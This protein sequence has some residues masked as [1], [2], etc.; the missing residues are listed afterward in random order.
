MLLLTGGQW[1]WGLSVWFTYIKIRLHAAQYSMCVC[2]SYICSLGAAFLCG[3]QVTRENWAPEPDKDIQ[4]AG[5]H[6]RPQHPVRAELEL[7]DILYWRSTE[8]RYLLISSG[9]CFSYFS[10]GISHI[11]PI[12][13]QI[14]FPI[15]SL[16]RSHLKTG[17]WTIRNLS[18]FRWHILFYA[19]KLHM[20]FPGRNRYILSETMAKIHLDLEC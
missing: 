6:G 4:L 15:S 16:G 17:K 5:V 12:W 10:V 20:Q 14:F 8:T 3:L 7:G 2:V 18:S 11:L 1:V 19:E 9:C 13:P